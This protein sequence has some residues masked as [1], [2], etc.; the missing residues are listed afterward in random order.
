MLI[1]TNANKTI[2]NIALGLKLS[3]ISIMLIWFTNPAYNFS[4]TWF[5]LAIIAVLPVIYK[6]SKKEILTNP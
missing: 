1:K 6:N 2:K 4:Y 3:F 5:I